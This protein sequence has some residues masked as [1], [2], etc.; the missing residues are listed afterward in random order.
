MGISKD[1]LRRLRELQVANPYPLE[2]IRKY[3]GTV[4]QEQE[5]HQLLSNCRASGEWF[6][7]HPDLLEMFT[8]SKYPE[9]GGVCKNDGY[10]ALLED[11]EKIH[12][13]ISKILSYEEKECRRRAGL[14]GRKR[15]C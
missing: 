13:K 12:S 9:E 1:P 2:I 10:T 14:E 4:E 7:D 5:L 6:W 15:M 3:K 11:V 8:L